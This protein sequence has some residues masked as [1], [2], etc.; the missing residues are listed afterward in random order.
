MR[1]FTMCLLVACWGTACATSSPASGDGG[2]RR[3]G[4]GGDAPALVCPSDSFMGY[5]TAGCRG[6]VARVCLGLQ[7][8]A[9]VVPTPFC[10]CDGTTVLSVDGTSEPFQMRGPC[11]DGGAPDDR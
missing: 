10:L 4:A 2:Q 11:P 8:D 6:D 5:A 3:D 7:M 1:H 9:S